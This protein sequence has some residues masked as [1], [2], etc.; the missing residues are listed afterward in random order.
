MPYAEFVLNEYLHNRFCGKCGEDIPQGA[1]YKSDPVTGLA[2]H[3]G[4]ARELY[5][6]TTPE[7]RNL[8]LKVV[9]LEKIVWEM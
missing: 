4:C 7:Y 5:P 2:Y 8:E 1:S 3:L 9:P 6:M